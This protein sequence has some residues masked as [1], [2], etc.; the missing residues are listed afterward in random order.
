MGEVFAGQTDSW[1][2]WM[3]EWLH[4]CTQALGVETEEDIHKLSTYF[5]HLR[6]RQVA[7]SGNDSEEKVGW[8]SRDSHS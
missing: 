4:G 2:E 1:N 8:P 7:A 6:E 3:T 5:M